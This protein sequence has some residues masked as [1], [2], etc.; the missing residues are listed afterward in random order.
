MS[1]HTLTKQIVAK[2]PTVQYGNVDLVIGLNSEFD[3]EGTAT[4]RA[5][6]ISK[7]GQLLDKMVA[8]E[9]LKFHKAIE[10]IAEQVTTLKV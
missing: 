10:D 6:T 2:I 9:Y 3:A 1:K 7:E 5:K 8:H 4:D